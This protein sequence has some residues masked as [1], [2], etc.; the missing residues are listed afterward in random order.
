ME[1]STPLQNIKASAHNIKVNKKHKKPIL[2]AIY[3][4]NLYTLV[5]IIYDIH[6]SLPPIDKFPSSLAAVH[7]QPLVAQSLQDL[8]PTKQWKVQRPQ[9]VSG[10]SQRP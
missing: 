2:S 5:R 4:Y 10:M 9:V 1:V 8:L 7:H 6:T 3:T